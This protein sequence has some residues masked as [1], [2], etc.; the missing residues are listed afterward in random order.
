ME[1]GNFRINFDVFCLIQ[2]MFNDNI[3]WLVAT[4]TAVGSLDRG[5]HDTF[6]MILEVFRP[7][8]AAFVIRKPLCDVRIPS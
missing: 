6:R 3:E 1:H 4:G 2:A 5:E 7:G 8:Q